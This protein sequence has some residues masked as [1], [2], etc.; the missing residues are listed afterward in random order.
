MTA[1]EL[2]YNI[3]GTGSHFFDRK[4]MKFFGDTMKNFGVS[5]AVIDTNHEKNVPVWVLYRKRAVKHGLN[6]SFYF[7]KDT[8]AQVFKKIEQ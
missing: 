3:E 1:S 7:H 6:K 8:F 5:G 4:T 2:K